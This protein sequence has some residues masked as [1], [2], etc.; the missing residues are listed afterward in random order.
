MQGECYAKKTKAREKWAYIGK[1][2]G[3]LRFRFAKYA[4][5]KNGYP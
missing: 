1:I 4:S 2:L 3:E 5:R